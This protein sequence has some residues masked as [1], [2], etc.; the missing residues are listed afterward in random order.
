M[1]GVVTAR[2]RRNGDMR[3]MRFAATEIAA[4]ARLPGPLTHAEAAMALYDALAALL[5]AKPDLPGDEAP[6]APRSVR[7]RL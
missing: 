2:D 3:G 7:G 4:A 5:P 1:V 6:T